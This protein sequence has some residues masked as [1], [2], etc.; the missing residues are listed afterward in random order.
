MGQNTR[1]VAMKFSLKNNRKRS[2]III[3]I[4]YS[5]VIVFIALDHLHSSV[6]R[7][8]C[9]CLLKDDFPKQ[10]LFIFTQLN[11]TIAQLRVLRWKQEHA[12]LYHCL[13]LCDWL[14]ALIHAQEYISL[15]FFP[16][17]KNCAGSVFFLYFFYSG[18]N[19]ALNTKIGFGTAK[20][21]QSVFKETKPW[22]CGAPGTIAS[23]LVAL[24]QEFCIITC[25]QFSYLMGMLQT[26][27]VKSLM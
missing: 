25:C 19:A 15:S 17:Q 3:I 11:L 5:F 9:A 2:N 22:C 10:I 4:T 27:L 23:V 21:P 20:V 24:V 18:N 13:L 1:N 6:I 12:F 26:R 8:W 7:T 16:K 14:H